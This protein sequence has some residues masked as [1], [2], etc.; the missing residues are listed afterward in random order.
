MIE[1]AIR[2]CSR[3]K[4][5]DLQRLVRFWGW[6]HRDLKMMR[7]C[8]ELLIH[9]NPQIAVHGLDAMKSLGAIEDVLRAEYERDHDALKFHTNLDGA[10]H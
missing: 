7:T 5:S 9:R 6:Q 4:G 8:I 1:R 2:F 3:G 10:A